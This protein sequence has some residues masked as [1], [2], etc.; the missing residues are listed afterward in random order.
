[1]KFFLDTARLEEIQAAAALGVLDGV[2]TNPSLMAKIGVRDVDAHYRTICDL[3]PGGDISAEVISTD[4][5]GMLAEGRRLAA[6]HPQIV[7]KIPLIPAG[8]Q[9]I[10][11]LSNEGIA[12]NCT[13]IFSPLQALI[14]AKA[15][16][17]YVSPFVGRLDDIAHDGMELIAQIREIFDNYD[18][19]TQILAASLRHPKHLVE[20]ARLGVDVATFPYSVLLQ[21]FK[22]PLTD[23]GLK[24]F[25]DDHAKAQEA[26]G[27][28]A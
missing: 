13:L 8:V 7:V 12:I 21:L 19:G 18:Y 11:T 10:S 24:Q 5:E 2:T 17:K 28:S 3:V 16:A 23:S 14:A 15:G 4:Y 27:R 9:A 26:L 20:A 6:L 1:M 25:L 22:H